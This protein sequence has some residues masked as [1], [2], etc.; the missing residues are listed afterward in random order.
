ML[1]LNSIFLIEE[2]DHNRLKFIKSKNKIYLL[3]ILF[4]KIINKE[5]KKE[6]IQ[7]N[8]KTVLIFCQMIIEAK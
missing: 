4:I 6:L 3:L 2:K 7:K 5:N 8:K 1:I